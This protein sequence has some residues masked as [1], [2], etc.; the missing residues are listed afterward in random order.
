MMIEEFRPG[1]YRHFKG[2]VYF[3]DTLMQDQEGQWR[4]HYCNAL[5]PT[6]WYARPLSEWDTDVRDRI[7]KDNVTQQTHRFERLTSCSPV[8]R[9]VSTEQLVRELSAREDSPLHGLDLE[10]LKSSMTCV[11]YCVGEFQPA[12]KDCGEGVY[13]HAVFETKE[14]AYHSRTFQSTPGSKIYKRTFIE[15]M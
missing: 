15:V 9:D 8:A 11:D 14:D 3:A 4:V 1:L 5:E 6:I 7:G 2:A 10:C 12:T 13:C